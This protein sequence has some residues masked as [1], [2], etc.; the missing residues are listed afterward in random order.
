MII[1]TKNFYLYIALLLLSIWVIF[2]TIL[3]SQSISGVVTVSRLLIE[4]VLGMLAL[5]LLRP[6]VKSSVIFFI[7]LGVINSLVITINILDKIVLNNSLGIGGAFEA[8]W[9]IHGDPTRSAGIFPSY[10]SSGLFLLL[11][12]YILNTNKVIDGGGKIFIN[13]L[14][15]FSLLFG[16]R[17]YLVFAL[18]LFFVKS[19]SVKHLF[20]VFL[21]VT[22][23]WIQIGENELV[24]YHINQ[25]ITPIISSFVKGDFSSDA[26]VVDLIDNEWVL[27]SDE[28]TIIL[29]NGGAKYSEIGGGDTLF[30][31]WL[32]FGGFPAVILIYF[33]IIIKAYYLFGRPRDLD[34]FIIWL[35]ILAGTLKSE[36]F[37]STGFFLILCLWPIKDTDVKNVH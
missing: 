8:F 15:I 5:M 26:S 18:L 28:I 14:F 25:R 19:R 36:S 27:P 10:Q 16:S 23:L 31:R 24:E 32:Y 3:H 22:L 30:F 35:A 2:V 13:F 29:G 9:G 7:S 33:V 20:F 34:S 6:S 37:I 1:S 11:S 21:A 17:F 12:I 4:Q